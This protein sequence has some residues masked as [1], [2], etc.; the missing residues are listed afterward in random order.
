MVDFDQVLAVNM[1]GT[2]LCSHS[3]IKVMDKQAPRTLKK[4]GREKD[5]GKEA[6]VNITSALSYVAVPGKVAYVT[7]KHAALGPT[8]ETGM[9]W[10]SR[11]L[12]ASGVAN[13]KLN[14]SP[15][16]PEERH[17]RQRFVPQLGQDTDV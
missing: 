13:Y 9:L 4:S 3:V 11:C 15:R 1:K 8:K 14:D 6:I 16:Y 5:L 17:S 12:S 2:L 10:R 7:S